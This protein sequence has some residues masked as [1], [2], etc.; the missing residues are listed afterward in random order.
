[1]NSVRDLD[2]KMKLMENNIR[3]EMEEIHNT[4]ND[5]YSSFHEHSG[6][7]TKKFQLINESLM[8]KFDDYDGIIS[9][10]QDNLIR[11]NS[12]F[13]KFISDQLEIHQKNNKALYDFIN[14]DIITLK[15]KVRSIYIRK[16][17]LKKL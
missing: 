1:M 12:K 10:F 6:G 16:I 14:S 9:K 2:T 11:E 8:E 3:R 13:T 7:V 15:E 17:T 5:I 4:K